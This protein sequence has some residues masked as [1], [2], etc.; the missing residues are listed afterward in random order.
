VGQSGQGAASSGPL[1]VRV[2]VDERTFAKKFIF[3]RSV[4]PQEA[5]TYLWGNPGNVNHL[6]PAET[7]AAGKARSYSLEKSDVETVMSL[8]AEVREAIIQGSVLRSKGKPYDFPQWV[9]Q[10]VRDDIQSQKLPRGV[11]RYP[12]VVP[13][14]DIVVWTGNIAVELY[15]EYPSDLGFYTEFTHGDSHEARLL[16]TVYTQFNRDMKYFVETQGRSP[17]SARSEIR[18]INDEVFKLVIEG[19]VAMLSTGVGISQ[20]NNVIRSSAGEISSAA[21]RSPRFSGSIPKIKPV[22]GRLNVGGGFE[23]P[24]YTNLNP[25]RGETGGPIS[26][27]PNLVK[28]SME[29]M[30]RLLE[31]GSVDEMIS[32]K[33][34]YVDV[35]WNQAATAAARVMRPG[36]KVSMNVWCDASQR[37]ALKAAFE[38]AGFKNVTLLGDGVG[39][40]LHAIR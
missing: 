20:V 40:M 38:R 17:E 24:H 30:D 2:E 1:S 18:R 15:M 22:G 5:S 13:W 12:G 35:N 36:G 9:P 4:T 31:A 26:G 14:G 28:G 32:N 25:L 29:E 33:L 6:R 21:R 8:R 16:H 11:K 37:A 3:S 19:S 39:T 34:R 23:T 7:A 27:I 10:N